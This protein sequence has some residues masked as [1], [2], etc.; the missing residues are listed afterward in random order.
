MSPVGWL[1]LLTA[2]W[3]QLYAA[4]VPSWRHGEYYSYGWYIPPIAAFFVWRVRHCYTSHDPEPLP[5]G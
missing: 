3:V 1:V 4:C 5:A 2:L